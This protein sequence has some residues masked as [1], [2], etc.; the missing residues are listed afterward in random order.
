MLD[1]EGIDVAAVVLDNGSGKC[2]AGVAGEKA[3]RSVISTIIGRPRVRS[4]MLG[5]GHRE[6]YI[7]EEAQ[8]KRGVLSLHY[9]MEHGI[10]TNW[11]DMEKIWRHLYE[12]ELKIK[13]GSRPVLLTEAPLNPRQNRE[14]MAEMM[15]ERF[16]VPAIYVALQAMLA[17][18]ASGHTTGIVLDSGDGVTHSVPLFEGHCLTHSVSRLDFAGRDITMYFSRLLMESGFTFQGSAEREIVR[19]IKETLCYIAMDPKKEMKKKRKDLLQVYYLPD[20]N[21]IHIG[22]PLFQAPEAL[23]KPIVAG[24]TDPGIHHMVLASIMKCDRDIHKH[25]LGN[26]VL[27]GGSTLFHG[28]DRRLLKEMQQ[29]VADGVAIRITAPPE[30]LHSSWI[31]ASIL[32]SLPSFSQ[33]WVSAD[34][35]KEGGPAAVHRKCF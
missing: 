33:M 8:A 23:F 7:G 35:Y 32:A 2:K 11:N 10:V 13:P 31:G 12:R 16:D 18:Y 14:K 27:A 4:A 20:G 17:L 26:V 24:I 15:F 29:Q 3:P 25:L 34:E 9:P 30:R 6:Y 5:A 28:I 22:S 19:N 21:C 1:E